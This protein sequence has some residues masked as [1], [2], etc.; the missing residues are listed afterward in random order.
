M[1]G[2]TPDEEQEWIQQEFHDV[3][4]EK[5][6]E[7][8]NMDSVRKLIAS[9]DTKEYAEYQFNDVVIRHRK[10]P[11]A[12]LRRMLGAS[13]LKLTGAED[14]LRTQDRIVYDALAEVCIDEPWTNP[15]VWAKVDAGTADGRVY[16]IFSEIMAKIGGGEKALQKFR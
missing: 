12:K 2:L 3:S 5:L 15:V 9:P 6:D 4:K 16:Q 1:S 11:T 13:K 7:I 14:P 10:F 8:G